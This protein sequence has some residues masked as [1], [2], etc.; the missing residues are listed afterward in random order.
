MTVRQ[1]LLEWSACR[2]DPELKERVRQ[3]LS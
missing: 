2:D 1:E 3:L